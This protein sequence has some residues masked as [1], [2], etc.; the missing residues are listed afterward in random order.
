LTSTALPHDIVEAAIKG[1]G[2]EKNK[3]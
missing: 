1:H 3:S 2:H